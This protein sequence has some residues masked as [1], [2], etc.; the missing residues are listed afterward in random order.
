MRSA[1]QS[2]NARNA[3]TPVSTRAEAPSFAP[4][5]A[6]STPSAG[7]TISTVPAR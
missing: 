1:I 4:V 2:Q 3:L 6:S 5:G 7:S